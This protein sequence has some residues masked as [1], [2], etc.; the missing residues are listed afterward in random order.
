MK[1]EDRQKRE[2]VRSARICNNQHSVSCM[3]ERLCLEWSSLR[4]WLPTINIFRLLCGISFVRLGSARRRATQ[5][6]NNEQKPKIVFG[7]LNSRHQ[8]AVHFTFSYL[9]RSPIWLYSAFLLLL[10]LFRCSLIRWLHI[11]SFLTTL[12]Q[13]HV[14]LTKLAYRIL[15]GSV[16][17]KTHQMRYYITKAVLAQSLHTNLCTVIQCIMDAMRTF[18]A[19]KWSKHLVNYSFDFHFRFCCFYSFFFH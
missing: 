16:A 15:C 2:S 4:R 19:N 18:R 13:S 17:R 6:T 14:R 5:G 9:S 11:Y 10:L 12:F 1:S 3:L 8:S 7:S